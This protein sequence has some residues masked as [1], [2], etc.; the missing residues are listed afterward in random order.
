MYDVVFFCSSINRGGSELSLLR[1]LKLTK[2]SYNALLVYYKDTSDMQM[3]EEFQ[4]VIKVKKI[5]EGEIIKAKVGVNCMISTTSS[6]FFDMI[7][8]NQYILWVQVNPKIYGNYRDFDRYD[9]FLTTSQYIKDIVLKYPNVI[10]SNV[11]LANPL[12]NA[13]DIK[14]KSEE[15]QDIIN[16]NN[17]NIITLARITSEKGYDYILEIAKR[18]KLR[19]IEFKW[20]M[21]GFVSPKEE[22][23]Y[24]KLLQMIEE[25]NLTNNIFFLGVCENPY[26]YLKQ[27]NINILLSK[28]EAWGLA[29]TEAKI[30]KVPSIVSNNSALKEQISD[31]IDGFLVDLPKVGSDYDFIVNKIIDLIVN[32]DLYNKVVSNLEKF[33]INEEKIIYEV[34]KCFYSSFKE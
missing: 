13:I 3:I 20:Y 17:F 6:A 7:S 14:M 33:R 12:V 5:T 27:A 31:G 15:S 30:L 19:N 25:N 22:E 21:L 9:K 28:D 10:D 8:A 1:Y 34:D 2:K 26:K 4:E 11:Y 29:L 24:Q 16:N 18:L 23:Y 32:K